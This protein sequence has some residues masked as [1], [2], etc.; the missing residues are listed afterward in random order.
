M[1]FE[2]DPEG[3]LGHPEGPLGHPEGPLGLPDVRVGQVVITSDVLYSSTILFSKGVL[4]LGCTTLERS[5]LTGLWYMYICY[6]PCRLVQVVRR[7]L[8]R[9]VLPA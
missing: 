8:L 3:P 4:S 5:V 6:A 1:F 2:P 7:D 9:R